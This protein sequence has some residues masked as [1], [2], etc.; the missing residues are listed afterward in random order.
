MSLISH[1]VFIDIVIHNEV[2]ILSINNLGWDISSNIVLEE[3]LTITCNRE[4][5]NWRYYK[6]L[7][8]MM[9]E[10][11]LPNVISD[12]IICFSFDPKLD[13]KWCSCIDS[14]ACIMGCYSVILKSP[15]LISSWRYAVQIC[16]MS[17][18]NY[19][20]VS[21]KKVNLKE[22]IFNR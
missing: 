3:Q 11:F 10:N 18:W 5:N 7:T 15:N 9:I 14:A 21:I 6:S 8:K 19:S 17:E 22:R 4:V 2:S 12:Q 20:S 13:C 1:Y 16:S